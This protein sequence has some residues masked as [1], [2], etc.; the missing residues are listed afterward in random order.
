MKRVYDFNS[1]TTPSGIIGRP[2]ELGWP[3][4]IWRVT[5]PQIK[6]NIE[7][8]FN[9]FEVC[10]LKLLAS[11]RYEAGD[12][13]KLMC[14]PVDLVDIILSRLY[15]RGKID[16]Y[17]K[18]L[19]DTQKAIERM[20]DDGQ[21]QENMKYETCVV[22]RECVSGAI[23]PMVKEAKLRA[24]EVN[25][26]G[27]IKSNGV[28]VF[29][30]NIRPA[31]KR[32]I[33]PA[34]KESHPPTV[35]D[36][37]VA[38]RTMVRRR[39]MS[40]MA[41]R[42]PQTKHVVVAD[43]SEKCSLRVRMVMQPNGDW[44]IL[45]P[46][47]KGWSP[48]VESAYMQLIG[49]DKKEERIFQKWQKNL[50]RPKASCANVAREKEPYDTH[51]NRTRYPEL[52]GTLLREHVDVYA[53]LEW[54]LYYALQSVD[55]KNAIQLLQIETRDGAERAVMSALKG[56]GGSVPE[57]ERI[58]MPALEQ[59]QDFDREEVARMQTVLPLAILAAQRNDN[60]RME[61][62]FSAY[63]D[64]V[65]RVN[66]L[67]TRRDLKQHGRT[68]WDEIYSNEDRAFMRQVVSILLP[69]IQFS[70]ASNADQKNDVQAFDDR[71]NASV[72]LQGVFGVAAFNRME[73]VLKEC[74]LQAEMF[75][76]RHFA[77][78][79]DG[80][81]DYCVDALPCVNDLYAACQCAFRPFLG[82]GNMKRF[83]LEE[84]SR[85][86]VAVGFRELPV[87]LRTVSDVNLRKTLAGDDQ[88]LGACALAWLHISED[89]YLRRTAI[90]QPS[91]LQDIHTL[92]VL[93]KHANQVC[94]MRP[95]D[96]YRVRKAT[97]QL[98]RNL[99]EG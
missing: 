88:T 20:G 39:R 80:G 66:D 78:H 69:S 25:D 84:V 73:S 12:L 48:E 60:L 26:N 74:L 93:R 29:L 95:K 55:T 99:T 71:L 47:G 17:N 59:V 15:D 46:F 52:L 72:C 85:R 34:G 7:R 91:L 18:L 33:R 90:R 79:I 50:S 28:N 38:L 63:P 2:R 53:G 54:A 89:A 1:V 41:C 27:S 6:K 49:K 4:E 13:A 35:E 24:A 77:A 23:L 92:L 43:N 21:T 19:P 76:C 81:D 58:P 75:W 83:S 37:V 11:Y 40:G 14:L 42:I 30:Y 97:Y 68:K 32:N 31:G 87:S 3:C 64:F 51:E 5:L 98:I 67:K 9:A 70:D 16:Q 56:L 45:N 57:D 86:A 94:L 44:R 10:T 96:L 22:F 61:A 65:S 82:V 8:E 62:V 36:V